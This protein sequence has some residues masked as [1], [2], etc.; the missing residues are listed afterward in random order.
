MKKFIALALVL[1]IT[2][3]MP[4]MAF[5]SYDSDNPDIEI[6]A[7]EVILKSRLRNHYSA[8]QVTIENKSDK[9]LK[10]VD[11]SFE[12]SK[13]GGEA[14]Y[15]SRINA[16][17]K[18]K[19]RVHQWQDWGLWT[20]GGAWVVAFCI[21]PFEYCFY[22]CTNR[23]MKTESLTYSYDA[24]FNS[25][26]YPGEKFEKLVLFPIDKNF[27]LRLT[28]RDKET[29]YLYTITKDKADFCY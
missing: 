5:I 2:S 7:K 17:E 12:G 26:F 3:T 29:G 16:D 19:D 11:G 28:F 9:V 21:A 1:L 23:K 10:L 15:D 27:Y 8:Y 13:T 24:F 18:L 20:L 4:A 22:I 14:Y 6:Q 25:D